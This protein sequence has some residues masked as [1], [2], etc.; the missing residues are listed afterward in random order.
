[1][2]YTDTINFVA[3]FPCQKHVLKHTPLLQIMQ[4]HDI[5]GSL[6]P[7]WILFINVLD[8]SD[9]KYNEHLAVFS[10]CILSFIMT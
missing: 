8:M 9:Q 7:D 4:I 2:N 5:L 6:D 10:P 3:R 1:M